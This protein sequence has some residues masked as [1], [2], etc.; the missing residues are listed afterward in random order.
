MKRW[1]AVSNLIL[2][3]AAYARAATIVTTQSGVSQVEIAGIKQVESSDAKTDGFVSVFALWGTQSTP[4]ARTAARSGAHEM[5]ANARIDDK[6]AF[7]GT[8]FSTV[9]SQAN[10]SIML[11]ADNLFVH[12]AVVDFVL[13]ASYLEVTSNVETS[14]VVLETTLL[15]DLRVC[16]AIACTLSD[17]RF[18]IQANLDASY[19]SFSW[20]SSPTGA[21]GLD[22]TPFQNPTITNTTTGNTFLHT[23]NVAFPFFQ[24]H[25]DLGTVPAGTPLTLEYIM[26]ARASGRGET[27]IGISSIN[28]PFLLG[29]DPVQMADPMTLTV[30]DGAAATPE[31]GSWLLC[32]SGAA[33]LAWSRA[34]RRRLP[35]SMRP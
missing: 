21:P 27:N 16:F 34:L 14:T 4:E 22:L 25:L 23:T 26:Q 1:V 24:G 13:P 6:H 3:A 35:G 18:H 10:Y 9:L 7:S 17:S 11:A 19:R 32:L 15:A 20:S 8:D 2:L 29:T 31:P 30:T 5:A 28:D 33:I 12:N